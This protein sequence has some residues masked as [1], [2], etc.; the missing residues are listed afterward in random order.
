MVFS[1]VAFLWKG[2]MDKRKSVC[3]KKNLFRARNDD[4][5]PEEEKNG[6]T[7]NSKFYRDSY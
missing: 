2:K 1:C 6:A 7:Q 3:P 5:Y 4:F